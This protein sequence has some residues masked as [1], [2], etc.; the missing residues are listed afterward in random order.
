MIS[1]YLITG[2]THGK[3]SARLSEIQENI[4][5]YEPKNTAIIILGDAGFNF[6][7]NK[8]DKIEKEKASAFGYTIY[9]VRGNHEERPE[10]MPNMIEEYDSEVQGIVYYERD[11]P[12]IKYF[13]DY[14]FYVINGYTF[15]VISGAYSVDK[16][17]ALQTNKP[18]FKDEQLSNREK[19]VVEQMLRH[20]K[21]DFV[22][23][24]TCPHSWMP[25]DLFLSTIDQ[26]F[27][28]KSTEIWL[29]ELKE[30]FEW[31]YW[32]FGHFH[33][34]RVIRKSDEK[35]V[36]ML[37]QNTVKMTDILNNN[38]IFVLEHDPKIDYPV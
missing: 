37:Y 29:D 1:N 14:G 36:Y 15:Y 21:V 31:K 5:D 6:W 11:F 30:E 20:N 13:K 25:T 26:A 18:W 9:C 35:F 24:H 32:L 4:P 28:D 2:D 7:L 12:N 27:V 17:Y 3:A 19:Y 38:L 22:I 8:T 34:N 10:N 33:G 16:Y 23:S